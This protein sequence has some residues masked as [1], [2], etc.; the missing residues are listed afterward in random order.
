M[1]YAV[2]RYIPLS[3]FLIFHCRR[4]KENG[5]SYVYSIFKFSIFSENK[6]TVEHAH[7]K[8][9]PV[10][11]SSVQL[12]RCDVGEAL[13]SSLCSDSSATK[14]RL[15]QTSE[16][17]RPINCQDLDENSLEATLRCIQDI[18]GLSAKSISCQSCK[19]ASGM[20]HA[21]WQRSSAAV[22]GLKSSRRNAQYITIIR[23]P[24]NGICTIDWR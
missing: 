15:R 17:C 23:P 20:T 1:A 18:K 16:N 24:N 12:M 7:N 14:Q 13:V 2:V 10:Q 19:S 6:K 4:K 22:M 21:A 8:S 11:F 3:P 5:C 9:T